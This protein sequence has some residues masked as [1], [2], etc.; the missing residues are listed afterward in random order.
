MVNIRTNWQRVGHRIIW[1]TTV[2]LFIII[3]ITMS[4]VQNHE[5][6]TVPKSPPKSGLI[7]IGQYKLSIRSG[8]NCLDWIGLRLW[9]GEGACWA[10]FTSTWVVIKWTVSHSK[11]RRRRRISAPGEEGPL[12][13]CPVEYW[14]LGHSLGCPALVPWLCLCASD[15]SSDHHTQ[16]TTMMWSRNNDLLHYRTHWWTLESRVASLCLIESTE[17]AVFNNL[18]SLWRFWRSLSVLCVSGHLDTGIQWQIN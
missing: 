11:S 13:V 12:V 3:I 1:K 9:C 18:D 16:T 4:I 17:C 5:K 10:S 8:T 15:C 7:F 6:W 2:Y 14:L